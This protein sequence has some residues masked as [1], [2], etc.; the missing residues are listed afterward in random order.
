MRILCRSELF[1]GLAI[2]RAIEDILWLAERRFPGEYGLIALGF[3]LDIGGQ[4]RP[5]LIG[6]GNGALTISA[7]LVQVHIN[8]VLGSGK[9]HSGCTH[10]H[11][12]FIGGVIVSAD[13]R[14]GQDSAVLGNSRSRRCPSLAG[15]GAN[16]IAQRHVRLVHVNAHMAALLAHSCSVLAYHILVAAG[17]RVVNMLGFAGGRGV[18]AVTVHDA[19]G[20]LFNS[21]HL[22]SNAGL[23]IVVT[24]LLTDRYPAG[25]QVAA[26]HVIG[27]ALGI[28]NVA[29]EGFIRSATHGTH[30]LLRCRI[31]LALVAELG[32]I[33]LQRNGVDGGGLRNV[34]DIDGQGIPIR[35]GGQVDCGEVRGCLGKDLFVVEPILR[36]DVVRLLA[37][38]AADVVHGAVVFVDLIAPEQIGPGKGVV[39]SGEYYVDPQLV[40]YLGD[41][42]IDL[43]V[44]TGFIGVIGRLVHR[45]DLPIRIAGLNVR[46]QPL[47][48]AAQLRSVSGIVDDGQVHIAV[49]AGIAAAAVAG[50]QAKHGFGLQGLALQLVVTKHLHHIG[51]AHGLAVKQAGVILPALI[52]IGVIHG[53]AGLEAEVPVLTLEDIADGGDIGQVLRLDVAQDEEVGVILLS[54][55]GGKGCLIRP[56]VAAAHLIVV[57][58]AGRQPGQENVIKVCRD[59]SALGKGHLGGIGRDS[60]PVL[61]AGYGIADALL[62]LHGGVADPADVLLGSLILGG[63][64]A[65]VIGQGFLGHVI[66]AHTVLEG[67][68]TGVILGVYHIFAGGLAE[69]IRGQLALFIGGAHQRVVSGHIDAHAHGGLTLGVHHGQRACAGFADDDGVRGNGVFRAH[70]QSCLG[71]IIGGV[72]PAIGEEAAALHGVAEKRTLGQVGRN[73]DTHRGHEAAVVPGHRLGVRLPGHIQGQLLAELAV[74]I[75]PLIA[76]GK[77]HLIVGEKVAPRQDGGGLGDGSVGGQQLQIHRLT[78]DGRLLQRLHLHGGSRGS[79]LHGEG[80]GLSSLVAEFIAQRD[81]DGMLAILQ[82]Q[83]VQIVHGAVRLSGILISV[84]AHHIDIVDIHADGV[85]I[86]AGGILVLHIVEHGGDVQ[87]GILQHRAVLQL[88]AVDGDGIH[89]GRVHIVHIGAVHKLEVIKVES[90]G[91]LGTHFRTRYVHQAEGHGGLD[92]EGG[93]LAGQISLQVFPAFPGD[94]GLYTVPFAVFIHTSFGLQ[95]VVVLNS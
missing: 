29:G 17:I 25:L 23:G 75:G 84:V 45:Q 14:F 50:I 62:A 56:Q 78:D 16:I 9:G 7:P 27:I 43:R 42:R 80:A 51:A 65:D 85:L 4:I 30:S 95:C 20:G 89:Y 92:A 37:A 72:G 21:G 11:I 73:A 83:V 28:H 90:A 31:Q 71:L 15:I 82:L 38:A 13:T 39:M 86:D 55:R 69:G 81:G 52:G 93:G 53:V 67:Q 5:D 2:G 49:G 22:F 68:Q 18:V 12:V 35:M 66:Y 6:Y 26:Q 40:H 76:V 64:E 44:T 8:A 24:D 34:V 87:L 32:T 91:R 74:A 1:E 54:V 79:L 77:E 59:I 63:V 47:Q 46:L 94:T 61:R 88:L 58:S 60:H 10:L 33:G 48:C 57:G 3:H 19:G 70:R 36:A 41:Q